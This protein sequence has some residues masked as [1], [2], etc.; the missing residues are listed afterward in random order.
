MASSRQAVSS[1]MRIESCDS[2]LTKNLH[3][4]LAEW[5]VLWGLPG[6][7]CGLGLTFS[8]RFRISLGRCA[9]ETGEIRLA[10]FLRDGPDELLTEALCHEA[11]HAAV[12]GLHGRG[13]K[14]HGGEWKNLM[15]LAGFAPR[16]KI[17]AA[18][19]DGIAP[20]L[21]INYRGRVWI[22]SCP[23]CHTSRAARTRVSFWRCSTCRKNGLEGRLI[24]NLIDPQRL[25]EESP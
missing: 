21:Q 9:S 6:Y 14:P 20:G 5:F 25:V 11:A 15:R 2:T 4:Q 7:E 1:L 12:F 10:A 19:L 22:H 3:R 18:L 16:A 13:P 17:P 23:V 24:V 8:D